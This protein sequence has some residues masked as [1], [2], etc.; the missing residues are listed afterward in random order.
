MRM[1]AP[2]LERKRLDRSMQ[3]CADQ[4]VSRVVPAAETRNRTQLARQLHRHRHKASKR[5][6]QRAIGRENNGDGVLL[7]ECR[8]IRS[9]GSDLERVAIAYALSEIQLRLSS[10]IPCFHETCL[11]ED[12]HDHATE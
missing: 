1:S 7:G 5:L 2:K 6:D 10:K 9:K 3:K 4:T 12:E 8:F 11:S